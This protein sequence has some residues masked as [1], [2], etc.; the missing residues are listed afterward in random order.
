[1]PEQTMREMRDHMNRTVDVLKTNLAKVQ[2]GRANPAMVEDVIVEYYGAPTPLKQ[3]ATIAR[4]RFFDTN[5]SPPATSMMA[6]L[7]K[8]GAALPG[9]PKAS[10]SGRMYQVASE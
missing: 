6:E 8:N 10:G 5:L 7:R 2:T 4:Y 9:L 1:M 3:L